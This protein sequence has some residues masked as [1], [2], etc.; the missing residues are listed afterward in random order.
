MSSTK[1]NSSEEAPPRAS[2]RPSPSALLWVA[3]AL[4]L[5]VALAWALNP[6]QPKLNPAPLGAPLPL[7][8]RLPR[9]FTPSDVTDLPEPPFPTLP[10]EQK[11][12]ALARMNAEP[13]S[14]GCKLSIATCR[15][16]DPACT[17]SKGLAGAITQSSGH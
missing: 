7:C 4:V 1:P 12:R 16:N 5:M 2:P 9:A 10:R 13:C 8:A 3:V 17:T 6:R 15:L 11:L 14:C